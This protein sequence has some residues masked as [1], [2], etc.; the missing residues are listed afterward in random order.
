MTC[1]CKPETYL[2]YIIS[3]KKINLFWEILV[4]ILC[5]FSI[6]S[7]FDFRN[8]ICHPFFS[9]LSRRWVLFNDVK[10]LVHDFNAE[11]QNVF[12]WSRY[13]YLSWTDLL[14][15]FKVIFYGEATKHQLQFGKN[16]LTFQTV[17]FIRKQP[18]FFLSN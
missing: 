15:N 6:V 11:F 17:Y 4:F 10:K 13:V 14:K 2:G 9:D 8:I 1:L 7:D 12:L 16:I 18:L 3:I 5:Y